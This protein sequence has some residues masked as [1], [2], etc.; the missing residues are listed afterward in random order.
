MASE[1]LEPGTFD[2]YRAIVPSVRLAPA[3][4]YGRRP[5]GLPLG[6]EKRHG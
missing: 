4:I 2:S 3:E 1:V 6:Q 5:A